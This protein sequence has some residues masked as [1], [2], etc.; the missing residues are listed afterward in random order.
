MKRMISLAAVLLLLLS[1]VGCGNQT[2][3]TD[4]LKKLGLDPRQ[5][6]TTLRV[7]S[8]KGFHDQALLNLIIEF[9][10]DLRNDLKQDDRWKPFPMDEDTD[11]WIARELRGISDFSHRISHGYYIILGDDPIRTDCEN[12]KNF[13]MAVYDN[14]RQVMYYCEI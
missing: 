1:I 10:H 9:Q 3:R 2:A 11:R 14:D 7:D 13:I 5:G 8:K 12:C 6:I 4:E